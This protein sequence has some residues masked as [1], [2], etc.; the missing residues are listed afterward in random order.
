MMTLIMVAV[1]TY[2][3]HDHDDC[4]YDEPNHGD[5]GHDDSDDDEHSFDLQYCCTDHLIFMKVIIVSY[6]DYHIMFIMLLH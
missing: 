1:S 2:E 4:H 3:D 6:Y 5:Y